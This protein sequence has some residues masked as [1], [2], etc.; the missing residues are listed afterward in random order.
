MSLPWQ[1]VFHRDSN[2]YWIQYIKRAAVNSGLSYWYLINTSFT[3]VLVGPGFL[4]RNQR[5]FWYSSRN[6]TLDLQILSSYWHVSGTMIYSLCWENL[7]WP[8]CRK[9]CIMTVRHHC[10]SWHTPGIILFYAKGV[11]FILYRLIGRKNLLAI[12][13]P[14]NDKK[15]KKT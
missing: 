13:S 7:R 12:T 15:R 10:C 5:Q 4:K 3:L 8:P 6:E 9:W 11:F 2:K 1:S 14:W